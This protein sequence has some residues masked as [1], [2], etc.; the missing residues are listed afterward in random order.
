MAEMKTGIFDTAE[1]LSDRVVP[2]LGIALTV[3]STVQLAP[4][5]NLVDRICRESYKIPTT[6]VKLFSFT[7][8]ARASQDYSS[9]R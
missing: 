9:K 8:V 4:M 5:L 6:D 2:G 7:L 3:S 1:R